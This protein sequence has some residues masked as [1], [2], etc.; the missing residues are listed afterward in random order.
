MK[1]LAVQ[2]SEQQ[3]KL[4]EIDREI[5]TLEHNFL[6]SDYG[7][8]RLGE[9]RAA[10]NKDKMLYHKDDQGL[11]RWHSGMAFVMSKFVRKTIGQK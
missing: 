7:K 9:W 2:V 4:G 1:E 5:Q 10:A 3:R 6:T 11:L 8:Q